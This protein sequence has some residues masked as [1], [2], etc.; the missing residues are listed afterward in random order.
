MHNSK[1]RRVFEYCHECG[2]MAAARTY[3]D[4]D[5]LGY[6]RN[7]HRKITGHITTSTFNHRKPPGFKE[8]AASTPEHPVHGLVEGKP[9]WQYIEA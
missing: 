5:G 7:E 4:V 2:W 3:S 8:G 9:S 1:H 6:L